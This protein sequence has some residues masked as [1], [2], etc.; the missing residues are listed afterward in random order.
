MVIKLDEPSG[1]VVWKTDCYQHRLLITQFVD[2]YQ[3]WRFFSDDIKNLEK[4]FNTIKT[5]AEKDDRLLEYMSMD[6]CYYKN[7]ELYDAIKNQSKK[8]KDAN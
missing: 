2:D 5:E 1:N 7:G 6:I 4:I 8:I 3:V